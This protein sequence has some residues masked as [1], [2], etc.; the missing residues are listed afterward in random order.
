MF[1]ANAYLPDIFFLQADLL[2]R[3]RARSMYQ[4]LAFYLGRFVADTPIV[5]TR[6][7]SS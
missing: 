5:L 4:P 1:T 6:D 2:P 7:P 3:D